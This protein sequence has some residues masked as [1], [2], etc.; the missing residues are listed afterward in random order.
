MKKTL[1]FSG[2]NT[3]CRFKAITYD[4]RRP[5]YL[6]SKRFTEI[7]ENLE[8]RY[9]IC[10]KLSHK[11]PFYSIQGCHPSTLRSTESGPF[12][13][14][15]CTTKAPFPILCV[16]FS[17]QRLCANANDSAD[18]LAWLDVAN[19]KALPFLLKH[20]LLIDSLA[21]LQICLVIF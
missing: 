19:L 4:C 21:T 12:F 5:T 9:L 14:S 7:N 6:F 11:S 13:Q 2:L 16:N 17:T 15:L 10:L 1:I 20:H 18:D 3:F 8:N